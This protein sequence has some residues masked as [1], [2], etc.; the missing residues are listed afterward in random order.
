M[1]DA[2]LGEVRLPGENMELLSITCIVIAG[3]Y[4]ERGP[5]TIV[6]HSQGQDVSCRLP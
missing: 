3:K 6:R 1:F 4:M 5:P 2:Y